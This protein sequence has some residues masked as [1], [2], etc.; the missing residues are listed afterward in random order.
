[1]ACRDLG[2]L[3]DLK[4]DLRRPK[5]RLDFLNMV[6]RRIRLCVVRHEVKSEK[7]EGETMSTYFQLHRWSTVVGWTHE[8]GNCSCPPRPLILKLKLLP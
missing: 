8:A 2:Y 4:T 5:S 7:V 1:M 3:I 6:L